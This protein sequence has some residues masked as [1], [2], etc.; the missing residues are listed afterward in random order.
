MKFRN[1]IL[2]LSFGMV[3]CVGLE[4]YPTSSYTDETY[5]KNAE[6]VRAAL[7]LGYNQCWS[8]D[9]YFANNALSDDVYGSRHSTNELQVVTGQANTASGRFEGEWDACYQE[10]RTVH[11][12]LDAQDRIDI[13][14]PEFKTRMLAELRL[15]RAWTYL[16][17]I[18][19]YGDVPFF[20]TNPS[21]EES[22]NIGVT[23]ENT[24]R[25]F[26]LEELEYVASVLPKNTEIPES[27]RGRY[28]SGTA[29]AIKA[30]TYFLNNDFENCAKECER[31]MDSQEYGTYALAEN[32]DELFKTGHYGPE[33]IMTI[34]TAYTDVTNIVR[35]WSPNNWLPQSVGSKGITSWSPTQEL[36]N[37]FRKKDGSIAADT[38]YDDR[39]LRFYTTIAYN[40]CSVAIPEQ[41]KSS[42]G[43][44]YS[45]DGGD[46]YVC[47][48]R[49]SDENEWTRQHTSDQNDGYTG[50]QDYTATGYY[51]LKNYAPE[52]IN[53]GGTSHKPIM[54]IRFAEILLMYAESMYE[55]GNM[56]AEIW[57]K[58]IRP[59]RQRAGFDESYCNYPGGDVRQAI[60]D[61][62]R[63]ELA[64]EGRRVFDLRRWAVMDDEGIKETG[65]AFLTSQ[66]TGAPF[67][68]NGENIVCQNKY[69]MKYWFAIPQ[70]DRDIN[71]NL[72]QNP[73]W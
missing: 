47:W 48:T 68:D 30:R 26:I 20:T 36:V 67:L 4:Q 12:S 71:K 25:N 6:N 56:T 59:L 54:E 39:D 66:A 29:I 58:T 45:P 23:D 46:S 65:A 52:T 43:G 40:G 2:F 33:S 70:A 55:T 69:N 21:L 24:I 49:K 62:R 37:V 9:Y 10:L 32:Y 61:E 63:A 14:D 11:T 73:G 18:T 42:L 53:A 50:S 7:Y 57:N 34:E 8:W 19:W 44:L 51:S 60:R 22:R 16:R 64:L 17:L 15:M 35:G 28:T 3:S 72:P 31:L 5:W 27:E 1:I 13:G 41:R 38:D